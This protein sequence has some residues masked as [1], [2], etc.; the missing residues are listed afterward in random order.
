MDVACLLV[1]EFMVALARRDAP[2]LRRRP[3]VV[4]GAPEEHAQVKAC[5]QEA[6]RAGV[7]AGTTLRKALALCPDAVFLPLKEAQVAA[8][9]KRIVDLLKAHSPAVEAIAP[10]HAHF[11]VRGLARMARM[12]DEQWLAE[13]HAAA[14]AETGLP[15]RLA[16]AETVFTAHAA[17]ASEVLSPQSSVLSEGTR[18]EARGTRG[19]P[20]VPSPQSSVLLIPPGESKQFLAGLPVEALPVE[21][22]VHQ[23]LRMFG[24]E[25]LGQVAELPFSALQAQFGREGARAWE[26]A[27]GQDDARII[28]GRE[29]VLV[30]EETDLPAPAALSEPL[31]AG[32]RQ[33]LQRALDRPEVRGQPVR[34]MDWQTVLESGEALNRRFVFREPTNDAAR[35]LF[36]ARAK[37]ERLQLPAA[38]ASISI[39]LSGICSEYGHQANLWPLGPRRWR[40]LE[41]AVEQLSARTGGPQVYRIVPIQPWS[42]IPERQLGLVAL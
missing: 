20:S 37:I 8:E 39:T 7:V 13:L 17:A 28:P 25:R 16:A 32:T 2:E 33:L 22:L 41:D 12:E 35:M 14:M 30:T 10:G 31:V 1:P 38:A 6:A 24:L 40:E 23:R 21:P 29:E 27:N 18:H 26:L 19:A 36:V 11:D 34:R 15:V 9:A 4:G 42:R 3:I 5:S